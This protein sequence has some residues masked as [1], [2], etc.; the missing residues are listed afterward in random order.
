MN[1]LRLFFAFF[2]LGGLLYFTTGSMLP[3]FANGKTWFWMSLSGVV[4][5]LF[6]DMRLFYSYTI[7]TAR[8]SQLLMT[9]APPF[10]ALFGW[11]ILG[12]KMSATGFFGM[13][14]TLSGIAIS[15]LKRNTKSTDATNQSTDATSQPN[16]VTSQYFNDTP[17]TPDYNETLIAGTSNLTVVTSC[18]KEKERVLADRFKPKLS[19]QLPL[20][21]VLLGIGGALG[22]GLGIVLSK[23]GMSFYQESAAGT[24]VFKYIPFAATQIRVITGTIGFIFIILLTKRGKLFLVVQSLAPS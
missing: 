17:Q 6:G 20:K 16:V 24:D 8:F 19:L 1:L 21:G 22:Q 10:A 23:H 11:M 9:L 13:A 5:F 14:V 2:L 7:I 18:D 15:I 12:E 4:G 3:L